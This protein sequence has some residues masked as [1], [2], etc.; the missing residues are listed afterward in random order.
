MPAPDTSVKL[1]HSAMVGAPT[2]SATAGSLIAVLDACLVNG[3]GAGGVDSITVA[4]GIATVI[5]GAGHPF[6]KGSVAEI[7]GAV[8]A[9]LNGQKRVLSIV[10][11]TTYTFDATGIAD[12]T[13]T[14]SITH[15]VAAAGWQKAFSGSDLAAYQSLDVASSQLYLRVD[16]TNN[17]VARVRGFE[18]MSS[19]NVGTGPFPTNLQSPGGADGLY[20]RKSNVT[21]PD[22]SGRAWIILADSRGFYVLRDHVSLAANN[23]GWMSISF[24]GDIKSNKSPDPYGFLVSS[25]G[26][27]VNNFASQEDGDL[28]RIST[29][30][31]AFAFLARGSSGLGGSSY[32]R[33]NAPTPAGFTNSYSGQT[34]AGFI[35]FPN[36]AD[37]GLYVSALHVIE[38]Y[39]SISYRGDYPGAYFAPQAIGNG[40]FPTRSEIDGVVSVPDRTLMAAL[41]HQGVM[42]FDVTGP[43]R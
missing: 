6:Q 25:A 24:F 36:V 43:W 19:I 16:D 31:D 4:G 1:F 40:V 26:S 10:S 11:A 37:N 42:F 23:S 29:T 35:Q 13:A 21:G 34:N 12:Q 20:V 15:K 38:P 30:A 3:F 28:A 17:S 5:R 27:N 33:R 2:L 41:S 18:T 14:G 22:S 32:T 8:P 39:G 7:A 9:G